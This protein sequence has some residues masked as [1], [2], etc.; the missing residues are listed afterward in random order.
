MKKTFLSLSVIILFIISTYLVLDSM[1]MDLFILLAAML[2]LLLLLFASS[3]MLALC[4]TYLVDLS[5]E[6]YES[7]ATTPQSRRESSET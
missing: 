5:Q 4:L 7:K 6:G 2:A 1:D 3:L